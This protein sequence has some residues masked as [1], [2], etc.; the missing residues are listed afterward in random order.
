MM[1]GVRRVECNPRLWVAESGAH[2]KIKADKAAII[3]RRIYPP[4]LSRGILIVLQIS[5]FESFPQGRRENIAGLRIQTAGKGVNSFGKAIRRRTESQPEC[6]PLGDFHS[7]RRDGR[8]Q[9]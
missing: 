6:K 3:K 8:Q 4:H 5:L 2:S 9:V 1:R 7:A